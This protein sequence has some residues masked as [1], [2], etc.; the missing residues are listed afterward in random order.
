M[1]KNWLEIDSRMTCIPAK[2]GEWE[3]FDSVFAYVAGRYLAVEGNAEV[4]EVSAQAISSAGKDDGEFW[5]DDDR[6]LKIYQMI[7]RA[8]EANLLSVHT[9]C[10]TIERFACRNPTT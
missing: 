9:D 2:D 3:D 8:V 7:Q 10:P 6:Y 1:A 4:A 5:C